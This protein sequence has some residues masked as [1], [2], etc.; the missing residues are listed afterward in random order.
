MRTPSARESTERLQA[1]SI[2]T[3]AQLKAKAET[4]DLAVGLE[5]AETELGVLDVAYDGATR[6][7]VAQQALRDQADRDADNTAR[8]CY[9]ATRAADGTAGGKGGR[10]QALYF[11]NGLI[12]LTG[13]PIDQQPGAMAILAGRLANDEDPSIAGHATAIGAAGDAL[14]SAVQAFEASLQSVQIVFG[15][16]LKARAAWIRI[17]ERTYGELVARVGKRSADGFFK[18]PKKL[19]KPKAPNLPPMPDLPTP[20]KR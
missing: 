16:V 9:L 7:M 8:Q 20:P 18:A 19:P 11:P 14:D 2:Y 6:S 10:K 15:Q 1:L 12:G 17:Y 4:K 5:K 13:M 3:A